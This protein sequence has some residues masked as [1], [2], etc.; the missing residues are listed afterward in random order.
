MRRRPHPLELKPIPEGSMA[1]ALAMA[2]TCRDVSEPQEAESICLDL[3]Q[4]EPE[5]QEAL[6]LLLL[7]RTDLL[8]EGLP[9]GVERA[10]EPLSRLTSEYERE[11]YAGIICERQA[12][13]LLRSRGRHTSFVAWEWFQYAMDHFEDAARSSPERVEPALRFNACVRLIERNRHCVPSPDEQ[14]EHGIE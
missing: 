8:D 4:V 2:Q 6:V 13:Y 10:R 14:G 9:G 7:A 3:L 11:Y 1:T 12:R 5:S